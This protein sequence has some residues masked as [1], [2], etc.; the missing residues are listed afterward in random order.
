MI[1]TSAPVPCRAV[2]VLTQVD[3]DRIAEL[4]ER[5]EFFWIDLSNPSDAEIEQLGEAL[6]LHPVA[7]EDTREFGQR[8]KLD[9]YGHHVLLVF[10]TARTTGDAGVAGR[11]AGG[12]HLPLG[13]IHGHRP[14]RR[15][16]DH[17]RP[18]APAR[19][20]RNRRRGGARLPP[21]RRAHR[22]VLPGDRGDR[23]AGRRARGRGA[24]PPPPRASPA[25]LPAQAVRAPAPSARLRSARPVPGAHARRSSGSRASSSARARTCATSA[26]TWC[27]WR[28]SSSA[29]STTSRR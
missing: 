5:D 15:V 10:Y 8:P 12:P 22:R 28:A 29:R 6:D 14:A 9:P 13:R 24:D 20:D 2:H 27:R 19:R 3:G 21:A 1:V 26:I 4:R 25:R 16:H 11:S 17:R 18:P 7:L 23:G